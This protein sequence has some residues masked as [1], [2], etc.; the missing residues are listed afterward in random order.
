MCAIGI[1][2]SKTRMAFEM[3]AVGGFLSTEDG[4]M[5]RT[6]LQLLASAL[7]FAAATAQG[8]LITNGGFE[9]PAPPLGGFTSFGTGTTFTGWDVVGVPGAVS[10]V[11][12]SFTSF[13][14]SFPGQS[15]AAWLD[16]TGNVSNHATGVQQAIATTPGTAYDVSFWVGNIVNPGGPY[17]STSTVNML[18]NGNPFFTASNTGGAGTTSQFWQHFTTTFTATGTST[19]LAFIN[20]DPVT[21]N[22]NGLDNLSVTVAQGPPSTVPEPSSLALLGTGL[23][24]VMPMFRRRRD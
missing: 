14:F 23:L 4:T 7:C 8:Q 3:R 22:S 18:L 19:I 9:T 21:D 16:L 11:S 20:G 1:A 10:I 17:G 13:G 6:Q 2:C 12:G 15:G 24:G 5:H